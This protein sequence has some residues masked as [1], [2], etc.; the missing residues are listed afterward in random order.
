MAVLQISESE[1]EIMKVLW[2]QS[3][4]AMPELVAAVLEENQWEAGT[5]KTLL[6]RLVKKRAVK[7]TGARRAYQYGPLVS[8]EEYAASAGDMLMRR[9]F[10][11][12]PAE[13]LSFFV[14]RQKL[15]AEDIAELKKLLDAAERK[16]K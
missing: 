2:R 13:M 11:E 14:A 1:A 16:L 12:T 6:T 3:P 10:N 7:V 5:V 4:L 15:S 8:R 9:A